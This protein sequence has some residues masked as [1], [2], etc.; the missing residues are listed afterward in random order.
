MVV[1][2][3]SAEER[4][5]IWKVEQWIAA[6]GEEQRLPPHLTQHNDYIDISTQKCLNSDK[7]ELKLHETGNFPSYPLE[8]LVSAENG[9]SNLEGGASSGLTRTLQGSSVSALW[10]STAVPGLT[11]RRAFNIASIPAHD[12]KHQRHSID[13]S[14]ITGIPQHTQEDFTV[15][16]SL[17]DGFKSLFQFGDIRKHVLTKSDLAP[18]D[19]HTLRANDIA[20]TT[21]LTPRA[22]LPSIGT[23]DNKESEFSPRHKRLTDKT[24]VTVRTAQEKTVRTLAQMQNMRQVAQRRLAESQ[25]NLS[26]VKQLVKKTCSTTAQRVTVSL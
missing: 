14:G 10:P 2:G 5:S 16:S 20:V 22:P 15:F 24:A 13:V 12:N 23:I 7:Q 4:S 18:S 8:Y 6:C 1:V 9:K 3:L 21:I 25:A 19:T 26:S 17:A 11:K